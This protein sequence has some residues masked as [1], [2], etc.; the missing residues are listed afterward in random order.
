MARLLEGI[1]RISG[2]ASFFAFELP[3]SKH[4]VY[5]FGDYH[6]SYANQCKEC[7]R[8]ASCKTI[9][10]V[11]ELA[12]RDAASNGTTLDVY[13]EFPYVAAGGEMRQ[14][15]LAR[16]D[17][18]F[19]RDG[20]AGEGKVM[21]R[22]F[23]K[24]PEYVGIFSLL[25]RRFAREFYGAKQA[26]QAQRFHYSDARYEV[27]VKRFL[28][29]RSERWIEQ[30]HAR[31]PDVKTFR[32]LLEAFVLGHTCP[33]SFQE[34]MSAIFGGAIEPY[35]PS[36]TSKRPGG[37]R[38]LHKI[39]KQVYKLPPALRAKVE[40]FIGEKLDGICQALELEL[41]YADGVRYLTGKNDGYDDRDATLAYIRASRLVNYTGL[42]TIFM[43][44]VTQ[45][46]MMD[47]YLLA[48]M[49]H[50]A[51]QDSAR[52][53]ASIVYAGDF[54]VGVYADFMARYLKLKPLGCQIPRL[55]LGLGDEELKAMVQRCVRVQLDGAC[56]L[57][58][59]LPSKHRRRAL[60][61]GANQIA[62]ADRVIRRVR[63]RRLRVKT[64]RRAA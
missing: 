22:L 27:N 41:R 37:R 43:E 28:S 3:G 55:P 59:V 21:S 45:T 35:E 26:G 32:R 50:F 8:D 38:G 39:S 11:I 42:F 16:V 2:P 9:V 49:L 4:G 58:P 53:G 5:L 20:K 17:E 6:F 52:W 19:M 46:I 31:V 15:L 33:R 40:A 23:G 14:Q 24:Q 61:P 56:D 1:S 54:H 29:P 48:R 18:L 36:L 7:D 30:F 47:V 60:D 13:M 34:E 51:S 10:D 57:A 64:E 62:A 12:R 63:D 44:L 25:Y